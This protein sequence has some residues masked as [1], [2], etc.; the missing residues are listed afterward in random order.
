MFKKHG[1]LNFH[2]MLTYLEDS[3]NNRDIKRSKISAYYCCNT[4]LNSHKT[5]HEKAD[6]V[7]GLKNMIETI[8]QK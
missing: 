8:E 3:L 1:K 6:F 2:D 7:T 4:M 5:D